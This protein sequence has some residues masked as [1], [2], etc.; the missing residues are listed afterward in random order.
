[1]LARIGVLVKMSAV[2][3]GQAVLVRGEMRG[4]PVQNHAD[5]VTVQDIDEVHEVLR[6]AVTRRRR[7]IARSLIAP[8]PVER[9]LGNGQQ[10]DVREALLPDVVGQLMRSI[11]IA[12]KVAARIASPGTEMNLIDGDRS[13]ER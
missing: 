10:L 7:E 8:R 5:A 11:A 13:V 4:D 2:E 9:V 3:V 1:A 12:Q 6:A